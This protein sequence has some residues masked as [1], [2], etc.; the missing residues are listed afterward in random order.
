V[1][2]GSSAAAYKLTRSA[3]GLAVDGQDVSFSS[4]AVV[5][6]ATFS[7]GIAPG[8]LF[9]I[10]GSGL[11][12]AG[13]PTKVTLDGE[14]AIVLS[15]T[16]FQV[17]AQVPPDFPAGSYTLRI[18][19]PFGATTQSIQVRETAPAI[20]L[21][22]ANQ[23]AAVNQGGEINSATRPAPRGGVVVIYGTG[24][25][26]VSSQGT[27]LVVRTPMTAVLNGAELPVAFAGLTPG[28]I[29]LYQANVLIPRTSPPGLNLPLSLRQA[30]SDSN[31]IYLAIQ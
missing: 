30:G 20:F 31:L 22:G 9:T 11:A 15:A 28:F 5:N 7:A 27:L 23:G 2:T 25:G 8:G 16:P 19:S 24:F 6:A 26:S 14:S 29:G 12:G 1:L 21:V 3:G 18:E 4:D 10:F 13:A 17:N